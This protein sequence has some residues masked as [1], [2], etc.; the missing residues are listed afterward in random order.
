MP[1]WKVRNRNAAAAGDSQRT[2]LLRGL[3]LAACWGA[4]FE[5]WILAAQLDGAE[6]A[7]PRLAR[8]FRVLE[9][10][11][12][13]G[14]AA[15][16]VA[17]ILALHPGVRRWPAA[18]RALLLGFGGLASCAWLSFVFIGAGPDPAIVRLTTDPL[19]MR[20]GAALLAAAVL[21]PAAVFALRALRRRDASSAR[22]AA[23]V[24]PVALAALGCALL[25]VPDFGRASRAAGADIF[26]FTVDTL[27]A[28][29]LGCYGYGPPTSPAIDRFCGESVV[30]ERAIAPAPST[31]PSYASIMTGLWPKQHGVYS[32]Y[33]K[34]ASSFRTLAERLR[35]RGYLTAAL[36]DGSFPGT[37]PN[38]GQGFEFVVQR[39]VTAA[40]PL[41]S[42]AE[43]VRT[44][45]YALLSAL[46][47]RAN[48]ATSATTLSARHRLSEFPADR[49]LFAHFYWPFPHAPYDPPE[50]FLR[51]IPAARDATR[52][53]ELIR[54][55][56]A[57]I[58]FADDQIRRLFG[59][60]ERLGRYREA[61]IVFAADHGE[62]LG[63]AVIEP[64]GETREFFGH[65]R[66]LFDASVR[67]PLAIRAPDAAKI[68][69]RRAPDVVSTVSI[70][71][72]LLAAIGVDYE[73]ELAAPLPLQAA[74]GAAG[75]AVSVARSSI[76]PIDVVSIRTRDWRLIE[77]RQ[78][79]PMLEL[80]REGRDEPSENAIS[81]HPEVARA[82]LA[83]LRDWDGPGDVERPPPDPPSLS[84]RER[85]SLEALGYLF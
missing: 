68:R 3:A 84:A 69:A 50:R 85:E 18:D 13:A 16:G 45:Y 57:E 55:Y 43:G 67:V 1:E 30:F 74:A 15:I 11:G 80:F 40:T 47:R 21:I 41:P 70:A 44:L 14:V 58:R 49:A 10:A 76:L 83:S 17:A 60:L 72:T 66:Y 8:L 20:A 29:H 48:W 59:A 28:D 39:G 54:R 31:M 52:K 63:R 22:R 4:A 71:S 79:S 27:R 24:A 65:S 56:D 12:F 81:D 61:W 64:G 5:C 62:E 36:L 26:L 2:G 37:F 19:S 42:P 34:V 78:P 51:E 23:E 38:L 33:R 25:M 82:L 6:F 77:T 46:S 53:A 73:D 9:T 7:M 35:E 75:F 32:N